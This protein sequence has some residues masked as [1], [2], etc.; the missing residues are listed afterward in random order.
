MIN[1]TM[2]GLFSKPVVTDEA[3]NSGTMN[4]T[5]NTSIGIADHIAATAFLLIFLL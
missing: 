5:S 1:K 2:I 3:L 4:T